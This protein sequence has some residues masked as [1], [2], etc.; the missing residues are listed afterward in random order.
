MDRRTFVSWVGVGW[1]AGCLPVAL[2]ACAPQNRVT[3]AASPAASPDASG[4]QVVG[5]VAD[6]DQAG[7]LE[8]EVTAGKA[9][10]I[11]D[12]ANAS[13]V[14]AVDA[15]CT[16]EGCAVKWQSTDKTYFCPCHDSK[17]AAAGQVLQGPAT[18]PLKTFSAKIEGDSVLVQS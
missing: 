14:I 6:L 13:A 4:F 3:S 5:T 7:F 12:P 9:I 1:L 15:K 8:T 18:T 11:R 2:A 16:H 10:V 17:F